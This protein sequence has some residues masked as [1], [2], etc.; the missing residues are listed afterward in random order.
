[1]LL[2]W[3]ARISYWKIGLAYAFIGVRHR[4]PAALGRGFRGSSGPGD[5]GRGIREDV[6]GMSTAIRP[7]PFAGAS[8]DQTTDILVVFGISGDLARV[9]TFRS[10]YAKGTWGPEVGDRLPDSDGGWHGPW[11]TP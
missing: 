7:R 4:R 10:L 1:M 5:D 3:E 2:L 9:M 11:V 6:A 8:S